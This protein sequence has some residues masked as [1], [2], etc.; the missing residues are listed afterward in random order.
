MDKIKYNELLDML[1]NI[2]FNIQELNEHI[3]EVKVLNTELIR[4]DDK[5]LCEDELNELID[6]N[7][8][9]SYELSSVVIPLIRNK[10]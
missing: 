3:E 9:I 4:I 7:S 8:S 6:S 1:N 2:V 5:A 10:I